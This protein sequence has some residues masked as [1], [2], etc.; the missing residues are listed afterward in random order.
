MENLLSARCPP[1]LFSKVLTARKTNLITARVPKNKRF[2]RKCSQM[3]AYANARD[4]PNGA[5]LFFKVLDLAYGRRYGKTDR[6]TY[7]QSHDNQFF[8]KPTGYQ[9]F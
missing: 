7:G 5:I 6:R 9:F 4:T 8:L 1:F 2:V 3:F